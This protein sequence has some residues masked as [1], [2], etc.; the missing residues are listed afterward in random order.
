MK[1]VKTNRA[2]LNPVNYPMSVL[3]LPRDRAFHVN[4][5]APV[6]FTIP[7]STQKLTAHQLQ[8][9]ATWFC[10]GTVLHY[11]DKVM[12]TKL[13]AIDQWTYQFVEDYPKHYSLMGMN[14]PQLAYDYGKKL[15]AACTKASTIPFYNLE[16]AYKDVMRTLWKQVLVYSPNKKTYLE[17]KAEKLALEELR[18]LSYASEEAQH[19]SEG[20]SDEDLTRY[21]GIFG[22]TIPDWAI[23]QTL[24]KT[25]R[26]GFAVMPQIEMTSNYQ[27]NFQKSGTVGYAGNEERDP[28]PFTL[29]KDAIPLKLNNSHL[30]AQLAEQIDWYLNTFN[31]THDT[32]LLAEGWA[33]CTT[34]GFYK[35][36]EGCECGAN[37]SLEEKELETIHEA[38]EA[39]QIFKNTYDGQLIEIAE[40]VKEVFGNPNEQDTEEILRAVI[41]KFGTIR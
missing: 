1:Y 20:Y 32:M 33:H 19:V 21:A 34:C 25:K 26:H 30:R 6:S 12:K 38:Y 39:M 4:Y 40:W 28:I 3:D 23:K 24:V 27:L 17:I 41:S 9:L 7:T 10:R 37:L 5:P 35:A 15:I 36:T 16:L 22:V 11:S 14:T 29:Q 8:T 13:R 31:E 2:K 18:A